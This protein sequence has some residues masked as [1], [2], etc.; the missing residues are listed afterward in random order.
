MYSPWDIEHPN[1]NLQE[2]DTGTQTESETDTETIYGDS[3]SRPVSPNKR[4]SQENFSHESEESVMGGPDE[5]PSQPKKTENEAATSAIV[6]IIQEAAN[7]Q[8]EKLEEMTDE[9]AKI[10]KSIHED[11]KRDHEKARRKKKKKSKKHE[12]DSDS[13]NYQDP[14][15]LIRER[16]LH[17]SSS[18]SRG[19]FNRETYYGGASRYEPPSSYS[20]YGAYGERPTESDRPF[21]FTRRRSRSPSPTPKY[22]FYSVISGGKHGIEGPIDTGGP[23][24]PSDPE[25]T[26]PKKPRK[27]KDGDKKRNRKKKPDPEDGGGDGGPGGPSDPDDGDG[28]DG[29]GSSDESED[30]GDN[31]RRRRRRRGN[32]VPGYISK[33]IPPPIFKG[34]PGERPEAHLLRALDWFDTIGAVR[35]RDRLSNFKH[36]LDHNAREWL[37]DL[38]MEEYG[39][40]TWPKC[41]EAFSRYFSTQG[42]SL[43]LLHK[44]WREFEFHPETDDIEE[45]IRNVQECARQLN[46]D[47]DATMNMIKSTMP[48]VCYGTLY[49]MTNLAETINFCKDYFARSPREQAQAAANA[50]DA[51]GTPFTHIKSKG[52]DFTQTL[53]KLTD[54]LNKFDIKQKPYKPTISPPRFRGRG[55]GRGRSFNPRDSKPRQNFSGGGRGRGG[56]RGR[57]RGGGGRFDKSPNKRNPRQN[58]KTK[59]VDRDRCR[60]CRE[61]G[62]W[63]R[64]CPQ[65]KA[66]QAK[67]GESQPPRSTYAAI[68]GAGETPVPEYYGTPDPSHAF[69]DVYNGITEVLRTEEEMLM[70]E[71]NTF[72]EDPMEEDL[73]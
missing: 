16:E 45:F 70:E 44:A 72:T 7:T 69:S 38:N 29:G 12:S 60:Y 34:T 51:T 64:E 65:K 41:V 25:D 61:I 19:S 11:I 33:R 20:A 32:R 47:N 23:G 17:G 57:S 2:T 35:N 15:R 68:A 37:H 14:T 48:K 43:P 53:H 21:Q 49:P 1:K 59:D 58:S 71:Y 6:D 52:Q 3:G 27:K 62:H 55:R 4:S 50:G 39:H 13:D 56:F 42:R 40:L 26:D 10:F 63:E 5:D 67:G 22:P 73:N 36:T 24:G 66:D 54:T 8:K 18:F 31:H 46:Y 28:G 9:I 30:D